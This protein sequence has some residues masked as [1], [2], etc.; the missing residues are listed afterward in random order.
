MAELNLGKVEKHSFWYN[1][2]AFYVRPAFLYFF[3][4]KAVVTGVENI[5]KNA[6]V[7]IAPNHQN[8]VLDALAI[9][10]SQKYQVVFLARS[11]VFKNPTI[12]KILFFLKILPVF[13]LQDG[14]EKLELNELVFQKSVEVLEHGRRVA[15]FPEAQHID[16]RHLRI[17]KKGIQRVAF[18][19][20]KKHDFKLGIQIVPTGIYYSNY[21][22]FRSVIQ[23]N[24]GKPIRVADYKELYYEN[25][26][27]AMLALRDEMS[28]RIKALM[29]DIH[30]LENYDVYETLC[31]ICDKPL[32]RLNGAKYFSQSEKFKADK[33][34]IERVEKIAKH[35][36]EVF[37]KIAENV[38]TYSA[39]LK[40]NRLKDWVVEQNASLSLIFLKMLLMLITLPIFLYGAVNNLITYL[41][42]YKITRK[43]KEPLF[44]GSIRFTLGML[45]YPFIYGIQTVAL[46]VVSGNWLYALGYFISLPVSGLIAFTWHRAFV[47]L[48]AQLR[49]FRNKKMSEY[50]SQ[51]SLRNE[52]L[53][54]VIQK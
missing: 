2:L 33:Q 6:P 27:K 47:K 10:F 36:P 43:L 54:T 41:L 23:V 50:A 37:A 4:K 5:P 28:L 46:G 11:D 38:R 12:A 52:I 14:K 40:S 7:L 44:T 45:S 17:L 39:F 19:A 25:E 18:D 29:I 34:T 30:D 48:T 51:I 32:M 20:E 21:F 3:F 22:N 35:S 9:I 16:K 42:P 24:Y 1:M 15:I 49:V 13:R 53:Q 26:Q 8:A 31:D